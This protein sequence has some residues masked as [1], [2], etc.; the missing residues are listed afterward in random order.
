MHR[1]SVFGLGPVGL[2][3]AVCIA[4]AGNS[5]VGIDPDVQRV[6]IINDGEAPFYEPSLREYLKEV[7]KKRSFSAT[8]NSVENAKSDVAFITVGTP[9]ARDGSI[10]LEY[11]KS[12]AESIGHSL[13]ARHGYQLVLI[14]STVI[15]GTNRQLV[16]PLIEKESGKVLGRDFGVC[17][18]PEFLHEGNAV[19]D[20]DSPDRIIIGGETHEV[21]VAEKFYSELYGKNLPALVRTNSETAELIK[22]ANNS[23]LAVKVSYIN[24]FANLCQEI[25][26]A[27]VEDIAKG[28]GL[29]KRIGS[30][31]LRAGLG[32][33]GSCFPK[34]L[35]AIA[36]FGKRIN[37]P[38]SLVDAA[39][40]LNEQ[41]PLKAIELAEKLVGNLTGKRVAVLGL[42]FKP[43]T[44]DL[45]EA[46][47]IPIVRDLLEKGAI[48]VAYD[49]TAIDNAK[50]I[51]G[52]RIEYAKDS[53]TCLDQS[54]CC[55]IATEWNEF[56]TIAPE[57]FL[58]K[59]RM[60]AIVDGRRI[61]D[62]PRFMRAGIKFAAIGLGQ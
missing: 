36:S 12:A 1:V 14:K 23:F 11:V 60:P 8:D 28:I 54:D 31:F 6:R 13:R 2:V 48:V 15:P 17:S 30:M 20:C 22:Y 44:D 43:D 62:P 56:K 35:R 47:S 37:V 24:M 5:V 27:D 58:N 51:F 41:Q 57:T 59:M 61:Y 9:G 26:G 18:N 3:T 39:I 38:T 16:K 42:A 55:I 25:P 52:N 49:P 34:D 29:D 33:G 40:S 45:R 10:N 32:W 50:T 53:V 4:H 19:Y 46:V 7:L 21:E